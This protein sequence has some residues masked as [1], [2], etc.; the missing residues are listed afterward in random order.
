M[1]LGV[2]GWRRVGVG[3]RCGACG[4]RDGW[5]LVALGDAGVRAQVAGWGPTRAGKAA[6]G[7]EP[8]R[9]FQGNQVVCGA[10]VEGWGDVASTDWMG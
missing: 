5:R 7:V 8:G 1:V 3:G 2:G 6:G 4:W 10:E 9:E